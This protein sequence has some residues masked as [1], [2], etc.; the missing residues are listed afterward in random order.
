MFCSR[1]RACTDLYTDGAGQGGQCTS[2][3]AE[4]M[5]LK[6]RHY[7]HEPLAKDRHF[8]AVSVLLEKS[9]S[10][11]RHGKGSPGILTRR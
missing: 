8:D 9:F 4:L 1:S 7:F 3:R 2:W 10:R 11:V 6:A 5:H